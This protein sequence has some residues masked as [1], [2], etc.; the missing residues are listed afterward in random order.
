MARAAKILGLA[1]LQ[2]KLDRLPKVA[3]EQI[4]LAMENVA[5]DI[6]AMARSLCPADSGALRES[7]GWTWGSPPRGSLTLGK[8]ARSSLGKDLTI[9]VYA[10]N[11][12]A[13]YVRWV[14]FG[15]APHVNGGLFAGTEHPGTTA[16]PFFFPAYRANRKPGMRR[17]RKAL[18]DAAKTVARS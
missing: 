6:V 1:K 16:Q 7:I 13:Y 11:N 15:T 4:R 9:T 17:I 5:N 8:V 2:R 3:R 14:E 10:G 18:R 12:E